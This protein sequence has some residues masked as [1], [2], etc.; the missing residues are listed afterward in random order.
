MVSP[1]TT[2]PMR[3][4]QG[5]VDPNHTYMFKSDEFGLF[6]YWYKDR[7]GNY[8]RYSNAPEGTLD[9]DPLNGPPILDASQ[10]MPSTAPEFYSPEGMKLNQAVPD[11]QELLMNE[12]YDAYSRTDCWVGAFFDKK[13]ESI[14]YVYSDTDVKE[15]PFLLAQQLIRTT[16]A[17]I[18]PFRTA[19]ADM[20]ESTDPRDKVIGIALLLCDQG[21]FLP[22]QVCNLTAG[23]VVFLDTSVQIGGRKFVFDEN[24]G[25]VLKSMAMNSSPE[26]PLFQT[27]TAMGP[28]ALGTGL[29]GAYFTYLKMSPNGL[30]LWHATSLYSKLFN[31]YSQSGLPFIDLDLQTLERVRLAMGAADSVEGWILPQ[32]REYLEQAYQSQMVKGLTA[33]AQDPFGVPV[34]RSDL[35]SYNGDEQEFSMWL[36]RAPM[37][38]VDP[39]KARMIE[40]QLTGAPLTQ[41]SEDQDAEQGE[42]ETAEDAE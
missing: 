24:V 34:L 13:T 2:S 9:Y 11:D 32:I 14:K 23:D 31:V 26:D 12:A 6:S 18:K 10:V 42:E 39:T 5:L 27:F 17:R 20:L 40:Q 35:R 4:L 28:L 22:E 30:I 1:L 41:T 33:A 25:A 7:A 16:D 38:Y 8:W 3:S 37:H 15:T 19:V 36:R 21:M 29:L